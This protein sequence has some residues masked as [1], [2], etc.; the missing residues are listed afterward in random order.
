MIGQRMIGIGLLSFPP[1]LVREYISRFELVSGAC[2]LDPFAKE[3]SG[4]QRP[5]VSD[6]NSGASASNRP[7]CLA[8]AKFFDMVAGKLREIGWGITRDFFN[9]GSHGAP[10]VLFVSCVQLQ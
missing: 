7:S 6:Q 3:K 2:V 10:T 1:H 4:S 5:D 9:V 8:G